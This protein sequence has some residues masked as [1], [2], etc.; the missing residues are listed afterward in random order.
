MYDIVLMLDFEAP[1]I[2]FQS[3]FRSVSYNHGDYQ[4]RSRILFY[5]LFHRQSGQVNK[6]HKVQIQE[7]TIACIVGIP[8]P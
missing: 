6:L 8:D 7:I 3:P 4:F 5:R 2:V 1:S